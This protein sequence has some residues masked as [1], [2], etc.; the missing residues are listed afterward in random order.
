MRAG[1]TGPKPRV[2][3]VLGERGAIGGVLFGWPLNSPPAQNKNNKILWV[4]R[5]YSKSIEPLWI[6]MQQMKGTRLVGAPTRRII[7][8]GP[9]PSYVDAPS[10]GCWRLTF[11]WSGR[12]DTLD[13]GYLPPTTTTPTTAVGSPVPDDVRNCGTRGD[14]NR[15][16]QPPASGAITVGPLVI[17]P[18]VRMPT[19]LTTIQAWPYA[20][21][22]PVLVRARARVTLAIAP[23]AVGLAGLWK[24]KGGYGSAVR[25]LAC[26]ERE[27]SRGYR[28][29][30]GRY[31]EFPFSFALTTPSTCVPMDVWVDGRA[32]PRRVVVP[33]GKR[34]C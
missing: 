24:M 14:S 17:W 23:E 27:P 34:A 15:P 31:T 29:T 7:P 16:A 12:R 6:R 26:R 5:R 25:F 10:A 21:K 3:Y 19:G 28:G 4:P 1:F 22:A 8:N 18:S 33:V 32:S 30:V 13:L 11:N 9:G 2:P 20:T